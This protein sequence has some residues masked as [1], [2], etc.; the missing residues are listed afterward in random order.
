[1]SNR[2]PPDGPL[3]EPG[4][5]CWRI[6]RAK[7]AALIVDADHYY[8]AA[9]RA[10]LAARHQILLMGWDVDTRISLDDDPQE[11]GP[12]CL[13]P[14]IAWLAKNRPELHIHI[15]AWDG[16]AYR[17]L[18]RGSTLFRIASWARHER[19]HYRFDGAH[20]REASHHQKIL[21]IDDCLAFCGGIDITGSRWDTRGHIDND[22]R[23]RRATTR[24]HYGPWH[25]ATM[26]V[27]GD[28]ARALGDL[29]RKRWKIA[30]EQELPCACK[31][32]GPWPKGVEPQFRELDIGIART[33]GKMDDLDEV[34]EIEAL[35]ADMIGAARRFVYAETQ[36]FAS[37]VIAEAIAKRMA[38]PDA[39][40]IVVVNPREG[41]GWLDE[42]IMGP[43]RAELM[44]AIAKVDRNRRF[45]IYSPVTEGGED[46]YVHAKIMIVDDHMLRVGS[47]NMNNRSMGL[48][49]ECDLLIEATAA[50]QAH[51]AAAIRRIRADLL[52]EHLGVEPDEVDRSCEAEGSLIG[53]IE[54]LRGTGRTLVPLAPREMGAVETAVA[55]SEVL[56]PESAE[57][58]FEPMA[59][60]RLLG[61]LRRIRGAF[62][63]RR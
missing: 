60:N 42:S 61:G 38:E 46:I 37:R 57:E 12:N 50:H 6:A 14:L 1:M 17:Y 49:S 28:A 26:V 22:P 45:R 34:R 25:D 51:S 33:R 40:E 3:L 39:P 62:P 47:A 53:A 9:R 58:P 32:P 44:R 29:G 48:D 36:Y 63:H 18:G 31:A 24:R 23:R 10:M 52:A 2:V 15:L 55:N 21:V 8:R 20:P 56:D 7:R 30:A 11:E 54:A 19:I 59:Q 5:N 41:Y 13:G 4:R 43:A 35:F 27:D 16:G